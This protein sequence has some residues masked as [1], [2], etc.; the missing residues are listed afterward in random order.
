M[1]ENRLRRMLLAVFLFGAAGLCFELVLLEHTEDAWQW[2]PII[3][4]GGGLGLAVAMVF[5]QRALLVRI[6]QFVMVLF[7][8]SGGIGF[9]LHFRGNV[10]FELEMYASMRGFELIW[11]SLK[12]ATPSLA[13]GTMTLLG[14]L[15]M[16]YSFRHPLL[17]V[18]VPSPAST[19]D[20]PA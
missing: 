6:F 10:E 19:K 14:L 12:G 18:T 9:I 7:I 15:G 4:L 3:L 11:E 17:R 5:T 8:G 1:D 13:P 20:D 16:I 2:A